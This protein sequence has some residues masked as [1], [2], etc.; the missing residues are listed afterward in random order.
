MIQLRHYKI[1][2]LNSGLTKAT[3]QIGIKNIAPDLSK[4]KDISEF[5]EKSGFATVI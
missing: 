2:L 1:N 3:K 4:F 5:M